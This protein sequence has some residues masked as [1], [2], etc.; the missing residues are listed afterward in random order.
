MEVEARRV[1]D[2]THVK[3]PLLVVDLAH[4]RIPRGPVGSQELML[5]SAASLFVPDSA[6]FPAV[7]A[8]SVVT[9]EGDDAALA[10]FV[11]AVFASG[12][13]LVAHN[14]AS[15]VQLLQRAATRLGLPAPVGQFFCTMRY[16]QRYST[17]HVYRGGRKVKKYPHLQELFRALT[18]EVV[19]KGGVVDDALQCFLCFKLM[20]WEAL[21]PDN[22]SGSF[23][24]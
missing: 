2:I 7:D 18:G 24:N 11:N 10:D 14:A 13:T 16:G 8:I 9:L 19:A 4:S 5:Y 12:A 21:G 6:T 3:Y 17:T 20:E 15:D 1:V 22:A 23:A